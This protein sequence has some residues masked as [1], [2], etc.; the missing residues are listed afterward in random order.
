MEGH[1]FITSEHCYQWNAA[2]EALR[3]DV[4]E[5]VIKAKCPWEAKQLAAPIKSQIVNWDQIK[6]GIMQNVLIAKAC[7]SERFKKDLIG[8]R[9]QTL[10]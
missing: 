4:A 5:A 1:T 9:W 10:M 2:L 3:D 6:Y 8:F 7:T